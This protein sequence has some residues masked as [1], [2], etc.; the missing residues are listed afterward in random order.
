MHFENEGVLDSTP[1]D[2]GL[3]HRSPFVEQIQ[4]RANV[5]NAVGGAVPDQRHS[6]FG[7][8]GISGIRDVLGTLH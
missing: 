4:R 7:Q 5:H 3:I 1:T 6:G 8:I 2:N